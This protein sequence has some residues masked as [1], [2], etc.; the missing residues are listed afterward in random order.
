MPPK[1]LN[2]DE[3]ADLRGRAEKFATGPRMTAAIQAA[4]A[5]PD[6]IRTAMKDPAGFLS[7]HGV[8]LPPSLDVEFYDREPRTMPGPDWFPFVLE[9]FNC[10][11]YFVSECDHQKTPPLCRWREESLCF[12]F[13]VYPRGIPTIG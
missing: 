7:S 2:P 10:R 1:S 11:T 13:R 9:F 12:G 5:N 3:L 8:K 4:L 6:D